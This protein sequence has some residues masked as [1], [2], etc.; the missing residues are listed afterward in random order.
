MGWAMLKLRQVNCD[1]HDFFSIWSGNKGRE[2]LTVAEETERDCEKDAGKKR[3]K[4]ELQMGLEMIDRYI[5][6]RHFTTAYKRF[7]SLAH[8]RPRLVLSEARLV[9][10]INGVEQE[11]RQDQLLRKLLI[12]YLQHYDRLAIPVRLKLVRRMVHMEQPRQALKT[13]GEIEVSTLSAAQKENLNQLIDLAKRQIA[14]G[15]IEVR[16]DDGAV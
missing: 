9:R 10:L 5:A 6:D 16:L 8:S 15:A 11:A 13:V 7:Q 4:Q 12:Y 14:D 1:G 3:R 2:Q